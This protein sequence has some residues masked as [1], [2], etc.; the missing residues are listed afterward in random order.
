MKRYIDEFT[1]YLKT[2]Q[3]RSENTLD[4]YTRDLTQ[5]CRYLA[6]LDM[7][8]LTI[9]KADVRTYMSCL[10]AIRER[11]TVARALASLKS[12]YGYLVAEGYVAVNPTTGI[13]ITRKEQHLPKY[14]TLQEVTAIISASELCI[15][16]NVIVNLLYSTGGRVS[17]VAA[18]RVEDFDFE[19]GIVK[20]VDGKGSKERHNPIHPAL[21][22]TIKKYLVAFNITSGFIFP[23]RLDKERHM[24]REGLLKVVKRLAVKAGVDKSKVS[25][26]KFR[27]SFATHMLDNGCD[28]AVVQDFLG[29]EDIATTKIYAKVTTANKKRNFMVHHPLA[30]LQTV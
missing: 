18:L 8:I 16:D 12:F 11:S 4:S 14:L 19:N 6:E 26:H 21:V 5:F 15:K 13:S 1:T 24:T 30:N 2:E 9:G 17:E 23:H 3:D 27:H 7:D 29:H 20:F 25:P 22:D 28:M 10:L